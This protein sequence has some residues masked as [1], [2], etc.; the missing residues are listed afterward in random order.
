MG[1]TDSFLHPQK[2]RHQKAQIQ[3]HLAVAATL[4]GRSGPHHPASDCI[5]AFGYGLFG[6]AGFDKDVLAFNEDETVMV[7]PT[8]TAQ[9]E[10][11]RR[12]RAEA[13]ALGPGELMGEDNGPG[14][15]ARRV[16]EEARVI[17]RE[18]KPDKEKGLRWVM[19]RLKL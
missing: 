17:L 10:E 5:Q 12:G 14:A 15:R 2:T 11:T 1:R 4:F 6:A 19:N 13:G 18:S 7:T 16:L 8:I 9:D 3:N